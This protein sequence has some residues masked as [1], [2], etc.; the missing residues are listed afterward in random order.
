MG[1]KII[2][3]VISLIC[4]VDILNIIYRI[5]FHFSLVAKY[6]INRTVEKTEFKEFV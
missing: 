1:Y 4:N 6:S 2:I 3:L 5:L